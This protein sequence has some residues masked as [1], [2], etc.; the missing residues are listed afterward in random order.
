[1]RASLRKTPAKLREAVASSDVAQQLARLL[2]QAADSDDA[3]LQ[4]LDRVLLSTLKP[5]L[6]R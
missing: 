3:F 1:V 2:D 5:R 6:E 4:R